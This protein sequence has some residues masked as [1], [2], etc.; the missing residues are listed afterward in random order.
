MVVVEDAITTGGSL[1]KAVDAVEALGAEVVAVV[2]L[3]DRGDAARPAIES[4]GIAYFPMATYGDLGI[5]PV[6]VQPG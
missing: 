3:I 6:V 2:T 4:R 1:L 5:D